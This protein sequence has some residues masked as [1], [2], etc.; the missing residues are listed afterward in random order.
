[1][2]NFVLAIKE[3]PFLYKLYRISALLVEFTPYYVVE[4]R[5]NELNEAN[6][7]PGK[8][9]LKID[10][11]TREEIELLANHEENDVAAKDLIRNFDNGC[12]CL[13]VRYKDQ[14]AAYMWCDLNCLKFKGRV[15]KLKQNHAYLFGARTYKAFRGNNLAPYLRNEL[16]KFLKQRGFERFYSITVWTNTAAMKFKRKLGAKPVELSLYVCLFRKFYMHFRLRNIA[17][18]Q[19]P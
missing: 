9:D 16:Y 5:Y 6:V 13:A 10:L 17:Y 7:L 8:E 19:L 12:S 1:M 4:E 18:Q 2:I 15:V 11:L 14:I 3:N